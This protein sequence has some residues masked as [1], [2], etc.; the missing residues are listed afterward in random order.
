VADGWQ[1][2]PK[3]NEAAIKAAWRSHLQP[4]DELVIPVPN[5]TW[6][7]STLESHSFRPELNKEFADRLL[8]A[9]RRCTQPGE[10]LWVIDWQHAWYSLDPHTARGSWPLAVLPDGD[11]C[12]CVATDFRFGVVTGWRATGPVTLFGADLLDAF[13]DDPPR[14]FLRACGPGVRI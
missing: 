5:W 8:A 14:E 13:A 3:A 4:A 7:G 2:I 11:S 9:F 6:S 10:R 1:P 12:N